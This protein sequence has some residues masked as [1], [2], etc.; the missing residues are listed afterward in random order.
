MNLNQ[1]YYFKMVAKLEHFRYAAELLNISQ[2]SLSYAISSLEAELGVELFEKQGRNVSLSKYGKVFLD[3]VST[4]LDTLD[5]GKKQIQSFGS[6]H[7]GHID[8]AY[9]APLALHYVPATVRS[10]L[11]QPHYKGHE[12][13]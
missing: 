9:V 7:S 2:P 5:K 10:F 11:D 4:A 13:I 1:L 12:L 3:Y 6:D 8:M